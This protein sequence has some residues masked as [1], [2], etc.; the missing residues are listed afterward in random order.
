MFAIEAQ[1]AGKLA[2]QL[3]PEAAL[4]MLI[5]AGLSERNCQLIQSITK[6]HNH[7]VFPAYRTLLADKQKIRPGQD[8]MKFTET[9]A[10]VRLNG[11]LRHTASRIYVFMSK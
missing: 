10:H 5:D 4:G 7:E 9:K 1:P 3:S 6:S 11:L 2:S 8:D